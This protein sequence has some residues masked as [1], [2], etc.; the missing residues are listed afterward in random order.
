MTL[1]RKLLTA[2]A[3]MLISVWSAA[4]QGTNVAAASIMPSLSAVVPSSYASAGQVANPLS[5]QQVIGH[6]N[7]APAAVTKALGAALR[8]RQAQAP[9]TRHVCYQAHVQYVGWQNFIAC[10]GTVAGTTGQG[11][12]MEALAITTTD[13]GGVCAAGH[14]Q[15]VGWQPVLCVNDGNTVVVGTTGQ[16]LRLEAVALSVG[17]G[18]VCANAHVQYIGWQGSVCGSSVTVGTTGQNLRM[19]AI[20]ITV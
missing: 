9:A 20:T 16:G 18:S 8:Q 5:G 1:W 4:M 3:V 11:L 10:D 6:R 15:N 2:A 17:S 19:E 12:R 13:V 7:A 14:V